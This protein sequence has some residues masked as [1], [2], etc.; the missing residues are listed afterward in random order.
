MARRMIRAVGIYPNFSKRRCRAVFGK[1]IEWLGREGCTV[2]VAEDLAGVAARDVQRASTAALARKID[3]L[4]V[5]GGDGTLLAA[6]RSLY[7]HEVP[8]LGVNFG[9]LGFLTVVPV[10]QL[11]ASLEATLRGDYSVGRRMMLR[12]TILAANGRPRATLYGLNDAVVHEAD[13]RLMA[14]T[15]AIGGM[16]VGVFRADGVVVATPTGSTAYSLSAGG[17]IIQ[18]L[19]DALIATPICPH[20]L[21]IRPL[22]FPA[23]ETIELRPETVGRQAR[24]AVDG[25][26]FLEL[27]PG[28]SVRI[29][30]A[31]KSSCFVQLGQRSFYEILSEKLKWGT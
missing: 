21:A 6:A 19:L 18:P 11:Y 1:L 23:Y 20:K 16:R 8:I 2:W 30:R 15:M 4:V 27:H 12:V 14:I 3:L 10:R 17:P 7:P 13:Q 31:E 5:L 24:L 25:Q 28:E 22:I 9:E 29:G 26:V